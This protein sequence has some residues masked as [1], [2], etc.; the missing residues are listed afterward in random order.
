MTSALWTIVG[1]FPGNAFAHDAISQAQLEAI[2]ERSGAGS[3]SVSTCF[4][5]VIPK[6][7]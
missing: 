5:F 2:L 4:G 3:I 6:A 7:T 1:R